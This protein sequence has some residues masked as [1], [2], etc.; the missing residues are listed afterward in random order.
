MSRP[1][2]GLLRNFLTVNRLTPNLN[3]FSDPNVTRDEN[4]RAIAYDWQYTGQSGNPGL[5]PMTA[6]QFDLTLEYYFGRSSSFTA[7][8]FYKKFY[9]YIQAGQ[10]NLEV[11]NNG[12]TEDVRVNRPVNGEGASIYGAD[13]AFQTFFD[14]LPA[15]FD[16]LGDPAN[17][18]RCTTKQCTWRSST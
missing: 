7:T 18:P 5:K 4:G 12:V 17:K 15:P 3:D 6:D 8:G 11:T 10:F 1:D 9:D 13:F 14:F 2:F 16:G